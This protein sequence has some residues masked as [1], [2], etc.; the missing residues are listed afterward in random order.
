[1]DCYS[2]NKVYNVNPFD[3]WRDPRVTL[4]NFQQGEFCFTLKRL[5]WNDIL[6]R[7]AAG[8]YT[9]LDG[10]KQHATWRHPDDNS[11]Q[12]KRPDWA[13]AIQRMPKSDRQQR[14]Q[15]KHGIPTAFVYEFYVD[16]VPRDW[17]WDQIF[18]NGASITE[19]LA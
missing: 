13:T 17:E 10:L 6:R 19:D 15:Q 18:Q 11:S 12:L 14:R 5:L 9:N 16:L 4:K 8:Y 2:G 7:E 3:F 1:V